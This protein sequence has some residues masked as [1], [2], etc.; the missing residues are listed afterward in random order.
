MAWPTPQDYVEAVQNPNYAFE[1]VDLKT[2]EAEQTPLGLPR[3]ISGQ[4]AC[5][6]KFS[7]G[8]RTWAVRCFARDFPD[9]QHRYEKITDVLKAEKLPFTAEFAY[10]QNGIRIRGLWYPIIKME[11]LSGQLLGNYI[12]TNASNSKELVNLAN[13]IAY[14]HTV[15]RSKGIAHGDLQHG[16]IIVCEG[17]LHLIDYD[18]MYVPSLSGIGSHELGHRN[19]QHPNRQENDFNQQIDTFSVWIIYL[20]LIALSLD[21]SLWTRLKGGD[22]SIL[23]KSSDYKDPYN[24]TAIETLKTH[25]NSTIQE[26]GF[27]IQALCYSDVDRLEHFT[28]NTNSNS[29][30]GSTPTTTPSIGNAWIKDWIPTNSSQNAVASASAEWITDHLPNEEIIFKE[31]KSG[32]Y[33]WIIKLSICSL[34]INM[35]PFI[36]FRALSSLVV[37]LVNILILGAS[38]YFLYIRFRRSAIFNQKLEAITKTTDLQHSIDKQAKDLSFLLASIRDKESS[39]QNLDASQRAETSKIEASLLT[40]MQQIQATLAADRQTL[41]TNKSQLLATRA[42][43]IS[44]IQTAH[45]NNVNILNRNIAALNAQIQTVLEQA[46]KKIQDQH[47]LAQLSR[48]TIVGASISGV[49]EKLSERLSRAGVHTAADATKWRVSAVEGIGAAKGA[50]IEK[51]RQNILNRATASMPKRLSNAEELQV[52]TNIQRT[53]TENQ[54]KINALEPQ[55]K[56]R[57]AEITNKFSLQI[58]ECDSKIKALELIKRNKEEQARM[59]S[60]QTLKTAIDKQRGSMKIL[61]EEIATMTNQRHTHE[62]EL[63]VMKYQHLLA[64]KRLLQFKNIKFTNWLKNQI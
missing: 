36:F 15:L 41:N 23:L 14:I 53:I 20:S 22:D 48:Y 49:G 35:L 28:V 3:V 56:A 16:N 39:K 12:A 57:I 7:S 58:N 8:K 64:T 44:A 55:L 34:F 40:T 19:Y 25:P 29:S 62:K 11:W 54:Q 37:A 21:S 24:S 60:A 18:G 42:S 61:V 17:N 6:F 33:S 52:R 32:L 45:T 10:I 31:E 51:W 9:N 43:E 30:L 38:S 4:F 59:L 63:S 5:V 27:Q 1:D 13:Q 2:A 50:A 47:V 26:I 46:L